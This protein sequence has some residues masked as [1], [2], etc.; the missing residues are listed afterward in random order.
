MTHSRLRRA[1]R[2]PAA[3]ARDDIDRVSTYSQP[4]VTPT[5]RSLLGRAI[6]CSDMAQQRHK[7]IRNREALV[8][9]E[10]VSGLTGAQRRVNQENPPMRICIIGNNGMTLCR[11][12]PATVNEGEIAVA[13]REELHAAPLREGLNKEL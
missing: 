12:A 3:P 10:S 9:E 1:W 2:S 7:I 4:P 5:R 11:E 6:P 8:R 13:S